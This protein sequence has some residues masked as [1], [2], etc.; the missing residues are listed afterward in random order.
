VTAAVVDR[1][2]LFRD[3]DRRIDGRPAPRRAARTSD[4]GRLTLGQRLDSVWE[5]LAADGGADCPVCRSGR[6]D[7]H[8]SCGSCGSTLS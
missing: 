4:G 5:G 8:G 2:R 1:P 3:T 7:R 6:M